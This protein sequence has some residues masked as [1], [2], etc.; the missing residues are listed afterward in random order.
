MSLAYTVKKNN[1]NNNKKNSTIYTPERVSLYLF[2]LLKKH[3]SPKI[4]LD[5]AIGQGSLTNPWKN[6]SRKIIGVDIDKKGKK[7]CDTFIHG[8]FEE[9]QEWK[10]KHPDLI[11]C[12]PP[13][14]G[15]SGKKLYPEVFLR[16]IVDLFGSQI[17]IVMIVPMGMRLNVR[18]Q[19]KRWNWMRDT[20]DISS[21][22]SLPID[23]F[24]LK[25]HTEILIFNVPS[26]KAHYFLGQ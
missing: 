2:N 11:L 15:A 8:K 10:H 23:C 20:L 14:N 19:S 18:I 4:I 6:K 7:H 1:Y 22:I 16:H 25:F 3:V 17:P 21:I 13:F 12:N 24:G 5:P 9:I 26:L